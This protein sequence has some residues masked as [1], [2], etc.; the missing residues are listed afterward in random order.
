M[1]NHV[2]C[3]FRSVLALCISSLSN[4]LKGPDYC[5]YNLE[6]IFFTIETVNLKF[7]TLVA[8]VSILI[9]LFFFNFCF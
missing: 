9:L 7:S 8:A 6:E 2:G 4:F 1:T 5:P 3:L